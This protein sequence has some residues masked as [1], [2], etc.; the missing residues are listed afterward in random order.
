MFT[1]LPFR[2]NTLDIGYETMKNLSGVI[3]IVRHIKSDSKRD[4]NVENVKVGTAIMT[5]VCYCFPSEAP[6]CTC[7]VWLQS[8]AQHPA[9]LPAGWYHRPA[10]LLR[11][12]T[13]ERSLPWMCGLF[14]PWVRPAHLSLTLKDSNNT[15]CT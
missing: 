5:F 6:S 2:N 12:S 8:R 3:V 10:G 9:A 4:L 1:W 15:V 11:F 14:P 13:L 7:P